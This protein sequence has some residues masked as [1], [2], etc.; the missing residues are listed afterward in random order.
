MKKLKWT[1][2]VL[3]GWASLGIVVS[4]L[5]LL[6]I[7]ILLSDGW[8]RA[9]AIFL[10]VV[11]LFITAMIRH[12]VGNGGGIVRVLEALERAN[13]KV[14][15]ISLDVEVPSK[16]MV[17]DLALQYN[18]FMERL[19]ATFDRQQKLNVRIAYI[20]ADARNL[21][22]ATR[23]ETSQQETVSEL[24]F[25]SS[26]QVGRSLDELTQRSTMLADMNSRNL[27]SARG[28]L[29][30]FTEVLSDIEQVAEMM[31]GFE[32]KVTELVASSDSIRELLNTVQSFAAQ[33]NM[34]ALNA[35]I[36]AARA[37]EQGRGFAVVAD[38]VRAL[39]GKVGGA[40]DQIDEL[41]DRMGT[42][43]RQAAEG[44][45]GVVENTGQALKTI[46]ASTERFQEMVNDFESSHADLLMVSSAV[47]ELAITNRESL[48][49]S[50]QI[51]ELGRRIHDGMEQAFAHADEMNETT[52]QAV[53]DYLS[54]HIGRGGLE[55]AIDLLRKREKIVAKMLSEILDSGIDVFDRNYIPIPNTDP[56]QYNVQWAEPLKKML[57][58]LMD[59]WFHNSEIKGLYF[60]LPV[61]DGGL[62]AVN[63]S[64]LSH[65]QVGD[66]EI[67]RKRGREKYIA[68]D[69]KRQEL[70]KTVNTVHIS[71]FTVI[72][73][74]IVFDLIIPLYVQ[75]RRWGT[76]NI[77]LQAEAFNLK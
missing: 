66:P 25:Q 1:D 6:S 32:G 71:T 39:A 41:V 51:R 29:A 31:G 35:A 33:T 65:P 36:E 30:E 3:N 16:G 74:V 59:Q 18:E 75:G 17:K 42:A 49:R 54:I 68:S 73:G 55:T 45:H 61:D 4:Q 22:T 64:E 43:V 28:S 70:L 53:D 12:L 52:N 63:R 37:G 9:L 23:N 69:K 67:D 11:G 56:Q 60:C 62:I 72:S 21:A 76:M 10:G 44:T 15:D 58:P 34:L 40:A 5:G 47:E 14:S 8:I 19:R 77:G 50:N 26:D 46:S 27:N 2:L 20:G 7:C 57:Q 38:E 24:N 48:E 13:Q